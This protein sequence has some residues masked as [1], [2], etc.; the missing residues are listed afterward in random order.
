MGFFMPI[1]FL[2]QH[3][4]GGI[5]LIQHDSPSLAEQKFKSNKRSYRWLSEVEA[6]LLFL[7]KLQNTGISS[8]PY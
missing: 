5:G 8:N 6:T 4:S 7:Q 2:F 3:A 1:R